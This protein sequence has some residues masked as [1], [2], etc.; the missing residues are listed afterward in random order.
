MLH[1]EKCGLFDSCTLPLTS[2][3][4]NGHSVE[5]LLL[6]SGYDLDIVLVHDGS[7]VGAVGVWGGLKYK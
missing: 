2:F 3:D 7:H 4:H 6:G 5:V 1:Q